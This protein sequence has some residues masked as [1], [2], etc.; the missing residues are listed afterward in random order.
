MKYLQGL[1]EARLS[2]L[3]LKMKDVKATLIGDMC[4]DVYWVADM[5]KSQLSRE[6]PHFP[7]PIIE[8]RFSPGA[9]GNAAVNLAT[10]CDNFVP[11]GI[12]GDDWRG[13]CLTQ[14]FLERGVSSDGLV[15]AQGI[16]TNAY[17]K[18]MRKGYLGIEVEDPRL[19]FESH[20]PVSRETEDELIEKLRL[21]AAT[22]DVLCVS[23][24]FENGC[25]TD[26]V[27]DAINELAERGLLTLVDSRNRIDRFRNCILKPN[28]IECAVA[29]GIDLSS[30]ACEDDFKAASECLARNAD[31][32]V[33]MT[34]GARGCLINKNGAF[35][36]VKALPVT[37]P[38]DTVGAG[39]CFLSAF[40]LA[41]AAGASDLEAGV[42][43]SL[44]SAVCVKKIGTTGS[45][46][47]FE[48][49]ELFSI[50]GEER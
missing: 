24:Q 32:D 2:E 42:I 18:P 9:G 34:L 25:I 43:A 35:T 12:V 8:E 4:L 23:D 40:A 36:R 7:L 39:D 49:S 37:S 20:T 6:T 19:D 22:A 33:C 50:H 21:Y 5:T 14:A 16:V 17:C 15:A 1:S 45:A 44:A 28:E 30:S 10:L 29:T 41:I 47:R 38:V 11:I 3:L 46:D 48:I 27:R 31:S 13:R 26:R